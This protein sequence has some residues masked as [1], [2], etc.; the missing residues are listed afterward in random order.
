MKSSANFYPQGF[1]K[2]GFN[3]KENGDVVYR[4]WAPNALRAYL[5]GDFSEIVILLRRKPYTYEDRFQI[6]GIATLRQ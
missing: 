1:E 2:F 4:E 6:I 3:V 5:I